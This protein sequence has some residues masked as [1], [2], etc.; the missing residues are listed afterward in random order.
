MSTMENTIREEKKKLQ[1][2]FAKTMILLLLIK[3]VIAVIYD[4]FF[5]G[6]K[7]L[8]ID[9]IVI[10]T[11]APCYIFT[12]LSLHYVFEKIGKLT[13]IYLIVLNT[14]L[15]LFYYQDFPSI[16]I[17]MFPFTIALLFFYN[18]KN[19]IVFTLASLITIPI[20]FIYNYYFGMSSEIARSY[21]FRFYNVFVVL[22]ALLLFI[23][24]L[25][26][27][28]QIQK[29]ETILKYLSKN[30][31]TIDRLYLLEK[32]RDIML[33]GD[34]REDDQLVPVYEKL[35]LKIEDFMHTQKP[36]KDPEYNLRKL[37]RD[38]NS[39]TQ[40]V[41][42]TINSYTKSNF[43]AYLNDFRLNAFI[44]SIDNKNEDFSLEEVYMTIGFYNRS[45]FNRV[46]KSKFQMTPQEYITSKANQ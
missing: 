12:L 18:F 13:V 22:N 27:I 10:L 31:I 23:I 20:S 43:K 14:A 26:Y 11:I 6:N 3:E 1:Y 39:N 38:V 36:W 42:T 45:T 4:L 44:A 46:F 32:G 37:S 17:Y 29:L 25:Y 35:F 5:F 8:F 41:S 16:I 40:Y 24:C 21:Y 33:G 19:T 28:F 15:T 9:L 7:Y 2:S 30:K 34:Y